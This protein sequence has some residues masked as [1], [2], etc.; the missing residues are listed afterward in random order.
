MHNSSN[1]CLEIYL[2]PWKILKKVKKY[3][4]VGYPRFGN[5]MQKSGFA[6]GKMW[7]FTS[8]F[9]EARMRRTG[10]AVPHIK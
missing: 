5:S 10:T 3:D 8:I 1:W 4:A 9:L 6:R 2:K 7:M